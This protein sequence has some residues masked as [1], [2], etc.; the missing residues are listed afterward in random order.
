MAKVRLHLEETLANGAILEVGPE[1]AH[2]LNTVLR[3]GPGKKLAVFNADDGEFEA[4]IESHAKR[5]CAVRVGVRC[6]PPAPEPDVWLVFA[7][8]KRARI[9]FLAGKAT[10]LGASALWPVMTAHTNVER[11]SL[12]RLRSNAVE[13]AEQCGRLSVPEIFRPDRLDSVLADWPDGR[14]LYWCDESGGGRA[15]TELFAEHRPAPAAILVG[16]EGGFTQAER[17]RLRSHDGASAIDLGP[18]LMRAETAAFAA[19]ACWQAM[20]G[21]WA[22]DD[23]RPG[24]AARLA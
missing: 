2:Y 8:I 14:H 6:R 21:D 9:D 13:A 15:A 1:R 7:P 3:M 18:R 22:A 10:E 17:A 20:L 5:R 11:V 12:D 4:V 16:P 23:G 24:A 19:L